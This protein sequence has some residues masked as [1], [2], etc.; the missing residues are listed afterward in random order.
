M[1]NRI[2][3]IASFDIEQNKK[4][5]RN[6]VLASTNKINYII[7]VLNDMNYGVDVISTSHT[8][9]RKCYSGKTLRWDNNTITLLPT[10]WRGKGLL[11]ILNLFVMNISLLITVLTKIKSMDTVI[12]YHSYGFLW[13][14]HILKL[15]KVKLINE[16]EEIYGDIFGRP[17]LSFMERRALSH[18]DSYIYPTKLLNMIVN[19]NNKPYLVV[20]GAYKDVGAKF[21]S[22][23]SK[24]NVEFDQGLFHIAYTGILDPRKGC[25]DVIRAAEFLDGSYYIHILGSGSDKEQKQ[26]AIEIEKIRERTECRISYDGIRRGLEY[27]NYLSQINLGICTLDTRQKFTLTQFP[28]KIISY[29]SVGVPVLCSEVRSI[30][31]CD[32]AQAITFY[33][34]NSPLDIARGIK[35]ARNKVKI[36]TIT[37]LNECDNSFKKELNE[38][39]SINKG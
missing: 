1:K 7:D 25:L 37:L 29:M 23:S 15:K 32:V 36:D 35:E 12:V 5:N 27:T 9:N 19:K 17:W 10:T 38:I 24:E 22:D 30:V 26:L 33:K 20:H 39:I 18:A 28:S 6:H 16:C 3:Y 4:E 34:G 14:N 2:F 21:F 31:D 11:K 8:M 13:L